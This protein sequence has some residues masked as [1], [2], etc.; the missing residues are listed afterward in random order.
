[1]W[2]VSVGGHMD[3]TPALSDGRAERT[4][5]P[6]GAYVPN[7]LGDSQPQPRRTSAFQAGHLQVLFTPTAVHPRSELP[8]IGGIQAA[9]GKSLV[10]E[11]V[12]EA[13]TLRGS[14]GE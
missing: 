12:E 7:P 1:M 9:P 13:S 2:T 3:G 11:H 5:T 10:S 6:P 8:I 14:F 4:R